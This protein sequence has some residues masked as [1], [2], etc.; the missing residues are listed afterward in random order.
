M[1][2]AFRQEGGDRRRL[3]VEQR[4]VDRIFDQPDI[5]LAGDLGDLAPAIHG[6]DRQRRI[7]KRG[8]EEGEL[9]VLLRA[10]PVE[11]LRHRAMLVDLHDDAA[12]ADQIGA[13][14]YRRIGELLEGDLVARCGHGRDHRHGG[15]VDADGRHDRLRI[16][17]PAVRR[18][19]ARA[20]LSPVERPGASI[21]DDLV[22]VL[23]GDVA[24]DPADDFALADV[25][26]RGAVHDQL[27]G[28]G[29]GSTGAGDLLGNGAFEL[30]GSASRPSTNVPLPTSPLT[31]PALD[32][33]GHRRGRSCR[34]SPQCH[35]QGRAAAAASCPAAEPAPI[36]SVSILSAS[37]M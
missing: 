25:R 2:G 5:V 28:N 35:R 26:R 4:A 17:L 23:P 11:I 31:K 21:V 13:A 27:A 10:E 30:S 8:D 22:G 15:S 34:L 3:L 36:I 14:R 29:V 6:R 9:R 33:Q 7:V 20:C 18:K 16:R 19:P 32:G 37:R 24:G 12:A 1:E